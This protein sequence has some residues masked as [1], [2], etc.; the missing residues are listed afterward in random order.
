MQGAEG[1]AAHAPALEPEYTGPDAGHLLIQAEWNGMQ[2]PIEPLWMDHIGKLAGM[3]GAKQVGTAAWQMAGAE[4]IEADIALPKKTEKRLW[5]GILVKDFLVLKFM[6]V[7]PIE[8]RRKIE[9]IATDCIKS[10]RFLPHVQTL[11]LSQDGLPLPS[12]SRAINPSQALKD[13]P[14]PENWQAFETDHILGGVQAFYF[15]EAPF[16]GWSIEEFLPYPGK[17]N[18]PFARL[19]LQKDDLVA[20]LGLIPSPQSAGTGEHKAWIAYTIRRQT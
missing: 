13:I 15:R 12:G 5:A 16:A 7:H 1:F 3:V 11:M 18:L 8:E 14:D 20:G 10:L 17:H 9:P 4:G 2:A 19:R 6:L